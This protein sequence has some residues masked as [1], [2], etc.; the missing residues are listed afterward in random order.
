MKFI[1]SCTL[2]ILFTLSCKDKDQKLGQV[3][4]TNSWTAA[5]AKAAGAT[6]V[7]V[8]APYEM[9]HPSEYELRAKDIPVLSHAK[10][11]IYAGYETMVQRIQTG[12]NL[13]KEVLLK[14]DT[15]YSMTSM[16]KSVME[17]AR[18]LGTEEIARQNLDSIRQTLADGKLLLQKAGIN[19][20]PVSV[21][22]FQ[23]SIVSEMG[24]PFDC[25][26]GPAPLEA[27]DMDR[28]SKSNS[29]AIVDNEHN[30]V[31]KP[32]QQVK[33]DAIYIQLLNFPGNHHTIT[34]KD[35][36]QFNISQLILLQKISQ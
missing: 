24:L 8:L 1:F 4:A 32:L 5:F 14:I 20:H 30:P 9:E 19:N 15:D 12:M 34:L 2:L 27:V 28:I 26:F 35:V 6:K 22:F 16:E 13:K 29:K 18:K 21:N 36:I 7:L 10:V 33:M 25:I 17:I 3:V 23:K 11:I 31:G